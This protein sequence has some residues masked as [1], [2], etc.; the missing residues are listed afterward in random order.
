MHWILIGFE[1]I[2]ENI[3]ELTYNKPVFFISSDPTDEIIVNE[4][5][6]NKQD[7]S[8]LYTSAT[9]RNNSA[10]YTQIHPA[11]KT[12]FDD[13]KIASMNRLQL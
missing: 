1:A 10:N 6:L 7:S 5:S 9:D 3:L 13:T 12:K 8:A 11:R 4:A 2:L